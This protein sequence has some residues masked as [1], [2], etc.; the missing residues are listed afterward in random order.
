MFAWGRGCEASNVIC[1]AIWP[2]RVVSASW[3]F[4]CG[5]MTTTACD[6]HVAN[7]G[8]PWCSSW[9]A[10]SK[11]SQHCN[12][13]PVLFFFSVLLELKCC[14]ARTDWKRLLF[15]IGKAD[16]PE[17]GLHREWPCCRALRFRAC[18]KNGQIAL[19]SIGRALTSFCKWTNIL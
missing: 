9:S 17:S 7:C 10:P 14:S 19:K 5:A 1:P 16:E 3:G 18:Q 12:S 2:V 13:P 11:S 4:C 15:K 8:A 6:P